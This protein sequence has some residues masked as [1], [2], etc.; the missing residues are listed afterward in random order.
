[1]TKKELIQQFNE[2]KIQPI[3]TSH[4][5]N[6]IGIA[7]CHIDYGTDDKVFG[8]ITN[9]EKRNFFFVKLKYLTDKIT[10]KVKN[11]TFDLSELIRV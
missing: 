9:G 5:T 11:M 3:A 6:N 10:F 7:I 2:G 4:I 1:M 8:Y